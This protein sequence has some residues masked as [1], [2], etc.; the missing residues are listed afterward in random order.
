MKQLILAIICACMALS[1]AAGVPKSDV[2]R[3]RQALKSKSTAINA[4]M[5]EGKVTPG[6]DR[7]SNK[8][9]RRLSPADLEGSRIAIV[10]AQALEDEYDFLLN[11]TVFNLG[12][13]SDIVIDEDN[14]C[15]ITN[16]YSNL[17]WPFLLNEE[18]G[19]V[20]I[21]QGCMYD[22]FIEGT[23]SSSGWG[24]RYR[25]DTT[26]TYFL[27][28]PDYLFYG[29]DIE[30]L[31][32][33]VYVDGSILFDGQFL[34]YTEEVQNT[35]TRNTNNLIS[36]DTLA[37][38]SPIY[39]DFTLLKPNGVHTFNYWITPGGSTLPIF[40]VSQ[41]QVN[42]MMS[43]SDGHGSLGHVVVGGIGGGIF[44]NGLRPRPI[45]PRKPNSKSAQPSSMTDDNDNSDGNTIL[46][47]SKLDNLSIRLKEISSIQPRILPDGVKPKPV[48]PRNPKPKSNPYLDRPLANNN[49]NTVV[50]SHNPNLT[51]LGLTQYPVYMYQY[52]DSTL[53]VY[54]MFNNGYTISFM[55]LDGD[56]NMTYPAQPIYYDGSCGEDY[57]NCSLVDNQLIGG[58][59]GIVAAD[60]IS[61]NKTYPHS[62]TYGATYAYNDNKLY[63]TDGSSFLLPPMLG[64]VNRDEV[65][66]IG[67]VTALISH[68]LSG[69]LFLSS[70]FSPYAADVTK[71]GDITVSDVTRLIGMVLS[72]TPGEE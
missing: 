46:G 14:F 57:Y 17:A 21:P 15:W 20:Y 65:I 59:T 60:T 33:T 12:W 24:A 10:A 4:S 48:D 66:N 47:K 22:E 3:V 42:S 63:F 23:V 11:D 2:S 27:Y 39:S 61:W 9:P 44:T 6:D 53:C 50:T 49:N 28:T 64:D 70:N 30:D 54:N 58:N 40:D 35:Y 41:F 72:H 51:E 52:D 69:N 18:N 56:G 8:A 37:Y 7:I 1:A 62:L 19:K 38:V 29:C 25:T 32:G 45:D 68:I 16:F 43:V 5:R 55:Y 36:S 34:I 26:R 13:N 71:D 67:D 31:V